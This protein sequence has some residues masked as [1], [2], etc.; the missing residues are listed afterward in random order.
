MGQMVC[1]ATTTTTTNTWPLSSGFLILSGYTGHTWPLRGDLILSGDTGHTWPLSSGLMI[2]SGDTGH[3]WPLSTGLMIL[4]GDTGP[5]DPCHLTRVHGTRVPH[6]SFVFDSFP[7]IC[8]E[9]NSN[10]SETYRTTRNLNVLILLP[11]LNG[12]FCQKIRH[13]SLSDS[14]S[15]TI[16]NALVILAVQA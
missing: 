8:L 4:S 7:L 2:L 12:F 5:M 13:E 16:R 15:P 11:L 9:V 1:P 6:I 3:T 10:P 14:L